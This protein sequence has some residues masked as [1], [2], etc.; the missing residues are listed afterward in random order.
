MDP[1]SEKLLGNLPIPMVAIHI[2]K[3]VVIVNSGKSMSQVVS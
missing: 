2:V 3:S 1:K